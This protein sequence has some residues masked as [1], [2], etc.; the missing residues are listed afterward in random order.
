MEG[1]IGGCFY[2]PCGPSGQGGHHRNLQFRAD[3]SESSRGSR[4]TKRTS[5][6]RHHVVE[7]QGEMHSA[8]PGRGHHRGLDKKV[9]FFYD[10]K[11][12]SRT[13]FCALNIKG[14]TK[15]I[16]TFL[17]SSS[18]RLVL[19]CFMFLLFLFAS[20][21]VFGE[22]PPSKGSFGLFG[23]VNFANLGGDFD[24]VGKLLADE[25]EIVGGGDWT[26]SATSRSDLCMGGYYLHGLSRS[27]GLQIEGQ[28]VRRGGAHDL[29][30]A[31]LPGIGS[32]EVETA[33]KLH[34]FEIP[35]LLRYRGNPDAKLRL[36]FLGGPVIG[37]KTSSTMVVSTL[38]E[39][40]RKDITDGVKS[41]TFG[42]LVGAG[43]AFNAGESTAVVIQGRYYMGLTEHFEDSTFSE[44]T[45]FSTKS[46]D[47]SFIAGLE[48]DLG[49]K[50][51]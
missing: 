15:M 29:Q 32:V 2:Y 7:L 30:G 24:E 26:S 37:I 14:E 43:I 51:E 19:P 50:G 45:T 44:D 34:Y 39:S 18:R 31:N 38:G 25:L 49:P 23:G 42:L 9:Q 46:G 28:Y 4:G 3:R 35:V 41:T 48:F 1:E 27:F 11:L 22:T 8:K 21:A 36:L 47:I 10:L 6:R 17:S 5:G 13:V 16:M 33:Y 12:G 20:S 40:T